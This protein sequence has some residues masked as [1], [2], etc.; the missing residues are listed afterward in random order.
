MTILRFNNFWAGTKSWANR[1][2]RPT[3]AMIWKSLRCCFKRI[4]VRTW[5]H[6]LVK[7]YTFSPPSAIAIGMNLTWEGIAGNAFH[8]FFIWISWKFHWLTI[9]STNWSCKISSAAWL[10]ESQAQSSN[11]TWS[12]EFPWTFNCLGFTF[13]VNVWTKNLWA[14]NLCAC[15]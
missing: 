12:F 3:R 1:C 6:S 9:I 15:N 7:I 5:K 11:Y 10:F 2:S 4:C 14:N 8:K 13:S